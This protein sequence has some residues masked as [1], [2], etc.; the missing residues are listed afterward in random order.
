[1]THRHTGAVLAAALLAVSCGTTTVTADP[2]PAVTVT[3]T[4]TAAPSPSESAITGLAK[5]PTGPYVRAEYEVT[6]TSE[7]DESREDLVFTLAEDGSFHAESTFAFAGSEP[8]VAI[9]AYDAGTET[10]WS[11]FESGSGTG[12]LEAYASRFVGLLQAPAIYQ[13]GRQEGAATVIAGVRAGT[14][15]PELADGR[16][17]ATLVA[18]LT[19]NES[20]G[21]T[22]GTLAT[23]VDL[24]TG[25]PVEID[26]DRGTYRRQVVLTSFTWELD[27][28]G[29]SFLP[30]EA[31]ELRDPVFVATTLAGAEGLVGYVP[32][33][34]ET[35]PA[36]FMLRSIVA[37]DQ[38]DNYFTGPEGL[39]PPGEGIVVASY[40]DGFHSFSVSFLRN[41]DPDGFGWADPLAGEGQAFSS[42]VLVLSGGAL[43]GAESYVSVDVNTSPHLWGVTEDLVFLVTGDLSRAELVAIAESFGT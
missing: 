13:L 24:T 42:E 18:P 34:P 19:A 26:E 29:V 1:M 35:L 41:V 3:E 40:R 15:T 12:E 17:V 20:A 27:D 38:P 4:E 16:T 32:P 8:S 36:G 14:I 9:E 30:D 7:F 43:A 10:L 25:L 5:V 23:T 6:T 2:S 39:N 28:P 11:A 31:A 37:A 21:L 33:L 22:Q